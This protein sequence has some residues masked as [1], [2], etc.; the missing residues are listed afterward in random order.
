MIFMSFFRGV[1]ILL[2]SV[3]TFFFDCE[4]R[5]LMNIGVEKDPY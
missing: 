5:N 3:V 2:G 4:D 1:F